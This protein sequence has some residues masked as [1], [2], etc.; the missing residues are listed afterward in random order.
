MSCLQI[1]FYDFQTLIENISEDNVVGVTVR[2]GMSSSVFQDALV[3]Q[4]CCP[5]VR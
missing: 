1:G 3:N 4:R 5:W 2:L